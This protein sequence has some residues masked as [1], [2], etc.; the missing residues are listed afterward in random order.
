MPPAPPEP[1][2]ELAQLQ[3]LL[4]LRTDLSKK[5]AKPNAEWTRGLLQ[6]I[7]TEFE[8]QR[9]EQRKLVQ[10]L[11]AGIKELMERIARRVTPEQPAAKRVRPPSMETCSYGDEGSDVRPTALV[12]AEPPGSLGILVGVPVPELAET[13]S[14]LRATE[15]V[16]ATEE[17]PAMESPT[18]P[19]SVAPSPSPTA[20]VR[21]AEEPTLLPIVSA[22]PRSS[23]VAEKVPS[24][25]A[26]ESAV[27]QLMAVF[28][29]ARR[30]GIDVG[31][32]DS[33]HLQDVP[34][35]GRG[36]PVQEEL[37]PAPWGRVHRSRLRASRLGRTSKCWSSARAGCM[38]VC[39]RHL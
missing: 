1:A 31:P 36:R 13:R 3:G 7:R 14:T 21:L 8:R 18:Q 9:R 27:R 28:A 17:V 38:H 12:A 11:S 26:V 22:A 10:L 39:V 20:E 24:D 25:A 19:R 33:V 30:L 23:A 16:A 32:R 37:V 34:R 2:S 29:A 4:S 5:V 35:D 15:S 6:Q